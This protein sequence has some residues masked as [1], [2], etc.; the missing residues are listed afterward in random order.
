[1][2]FWS[3]WGI[4]FSFFFRACF[5]NNKSLNF[6]IFCN[7]DRLKI[8]QNIKF[9]VFFLLN[10][11]LSPLEFYYKQQKRN[12]DTPSIFC[13]KIFFIIYKLSF[14]HKCKSKFCKPSCHYTTRIHILQFLI[15]CSSSPSESS[16]KVSL[17]SRLLFNSLFIIF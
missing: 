11:Y 17:K 12:E 7:L 4:S 10:H 2:I 1:M 8:S 15:T 9:W 6:L 3:S 13:I 5:P 14:P 16:P